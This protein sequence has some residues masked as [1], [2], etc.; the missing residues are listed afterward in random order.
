MTDALTTPHK[1]YRRGLCLAFLSGLLIMLLVLLPIIIRDGGYFIYYGDYNAQ[2]IPFYHLAAEQ[3]RNGFGWSWTTDLGSDFIGSYA[4]YLLGSPFFWLCALL[5]SDA[6]IYAMPFILALKYGIA[7]CTAFAFIRRFTRTDTAAVIGGLLYAFSGFQLFNLTFNHFHDVTALF[8]LMLISLEELISNNRKGAFALSTALMAVVNY[9]FFVGEA[10]FLVIYF[11]IRCFSKDFPVTLKKSALLLFEAV[12]GVSLACFMLMPAAMAV[13]GNPRLDLSLSGIDMLLYNAPVIQ[14]IIKGFFML[15]DMASRMN[16]FA[17]ETTE[18]ASIGGY[19]PLFSMAGVIAFGFGN[20]RH[21]ASRLILVSIIFACI[22]VLNSLFFALNGTYYGRWFF[23]PVLI[24]AL[25]TSLSLEEKKLPHTAGAVISAAVIAVM[26]LLAVS[27]INTSQSFMHD[28]SLRFPAE[29]WCA[30][31][32]CLVSLIAAAG[33]FILMKKGRDILKYALPLTI[34]ACT[35]CSMWA[36]YFPTADA[37]E[38]AAYAD[39]AIDPENDMTVEISE[40]EFFRIDQ[41]RE[42]VNYSM[43]WD[44]PSMDSFHSIVP[45]SVTEFYDSLSIQRTVLSDAD[46][47]Y[48][49]LRQLLSVKYYFGSEGEEL[50]G[51]EYTGDINGMPLYENRAVLPMGFAYDSYIPENVWKRCYME[52]RCN[53]LLRALVLNDE[54]IGKYKD[55]LTPLS[56]EE[57][58]M[59]EEELFTEIEKRR[60]MSCKSFRYDSE[61]FTAEFSSDKNSLVFFSVPYTEGW[62]AEINGEPAEIERVQGG[63]MAVYAPSGESFIEFTYETP[64]LKAGAMVSLTGAAVL[65][66][67]MITGYIIRK[68]QRRDEN[69]S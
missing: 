39:M 38:A 7:A 43:L 23:M 55:I 69:A 62:T 16:L 13:A 15:P 31:I 44:L 3:V 56:A 6:V 60:D 36:V 54:Q 63:F 28:G 9:F 2:Q 48:Y 33:L 40:N 50:P 34:A 14:N 18:F 12:I 17:S 20:R 64:G 25:M 52:S 68:K 59:T 19:L 4:F 29:F 5:P 51:F 47:D 66:V 41:S 67:Y 35:G 58:D 65:M 1:N 24:M 46:T 8:P 10:V 53:L 37:E 45:A 27:G 26:A 22:P 30:V 42:Y 49:A 61:G 11:I 21:W 57:T 32:L